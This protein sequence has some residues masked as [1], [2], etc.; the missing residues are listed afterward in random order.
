MREVR[1]LNLNY[2]WK[3]DGENAKA[4]LI[5]GLRRKKTMVGREKFE[6]K[7]LEYENAK[8]KN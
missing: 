7:R 2:K 5:T 8:Y 3:D 6:E 4:K 1:K